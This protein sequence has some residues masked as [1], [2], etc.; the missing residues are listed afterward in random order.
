VSSDGSTTCVELFDG[1]EPIAVWPLADV[2]RDIAVVDGLARLQ[3]A[4]RRVGWSIRIR[5]AD[6]ELCAIVRFAGL[7]DV[8]PL[9]PG[10]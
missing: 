10:R 9:E 5:N 3:L 7:A 6:E 4:A 8:L 2:R 1:T